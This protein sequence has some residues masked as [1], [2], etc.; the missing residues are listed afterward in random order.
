MRHISVHRDDLAVNSAKYRLLSFDVVWKGPQT[1]VCKYSRHHSFYGYWRK[2][3]DLTSWH[4]LSTHILQYWQ[5][6][7]LLQRSRSLAVTTN[8]DIIVRWSTCLNSSCQV[9]FEAISVS[10]NVELSKFHNLFI[11]VS[12]VTPVFLS[13]SPA[14]K[15]LKL[16]WN[17]FEQCD[18]SQ[19]PTDLFS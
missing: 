19:F 8:T 18:V 3:R 7:D 10:W 9:P 12:T 16:T 15:A 2:F 1:S 4:F 13:E 14:V 6:M 17:L 5:V 11:N